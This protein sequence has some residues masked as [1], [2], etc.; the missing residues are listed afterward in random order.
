MCRA[1][2]AASHL[3]LPTHPRLPRVLG[4][5]STAKVARLAGELLRGLNPVVGAQAR[6]NSPRLMIPRIST[7]QL[8][9]VAGSA[10]GLYGGTQLLSV[11]NKPR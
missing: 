2:D 7:G 3:K 6:S 8:Q 11:C 10:P 5:V 9:P 1:P 4:P